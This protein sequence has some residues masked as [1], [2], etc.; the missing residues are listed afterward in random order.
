[1]EFWKTFYKSLPQGFIPDTQVWYTIDSI[2]KILKHV[3]K[4]SQYNHLHFPDFGGHDLKNIH[5]AHEQDC[6]CLT[7]GGYYYILKPKALYLENFS[8]NSLWNYF[9]LE[10]DVLDA[11]TNQ[12]EY[13]EEL[14]EDCT[15]NYIVCPD[16]HYGVYD[17]DSGKKLPQNSRLITR[18]LKGNFLLV[19]KASVYNQNIADYNGGHSKLTLMEFRKKMEQ[20]I[21]VSKKKKNS[22]PSTPN[23]ISKS[24]AFDIFAL[25]NDSVRDLVDSMSFKLEKYNQKEERVAYYFKVKIFPSTLSEEEYSILNNSGQFQLNLKSEEIYYMFDRDKALKLVDNLEK[26]MK[27]AIQKMALSLEQIQVEVQ[28]KK[29]SNPSDSFTKKSIEDCMRQADDRQLNALVVDEYGKAS[30][31]NNPRYFKSFPVYHVFNR[32]CNIIGKYSNLPSFD[33]HYQSLLDAWLYYLKN[34]ARKD[35]KMS[36]NV[37]FH[38][39]KELENVIKFII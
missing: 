14:V 18:F 20:C 21:E 31:I 11:I 33:Y 30:I 5:S 32:G 17:Y 2:S 3:C 4:Y 27:Q 19:S 10:L 29:I 24:S 8:N 7:L 16:A 37:D 9:I 22:L 13:Q 34:G 28:I 23:N 26:A 12:N 39:V 1:M 6:I 15:G 35:T 38:N 36:I 25:R